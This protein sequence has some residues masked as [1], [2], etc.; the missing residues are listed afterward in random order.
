MFQF[1]V[2]PRLAFANDQVGWSKTYLFNTV[3]VSE[4]KILQQ[5]KISRES[6]TVELVSARANLAQKDAD[7]KSQWIETFGLTDKAKVGVV[8]KAAKSFSGWT[9]FIDEWATANSLSI[10]NRKL[11][12]KIEKAYRS[13]P[14]ACQMKDSEAAVYRDHHLGLLTGANTTSVNSQNLVSVISSWNTNKVECLSMKL[15][16]T[17]SEE[18]SKG[19]DPA[20]LFRALEQT[21]DS[22]IEVSHYTANIKFLHATRLVQ[23]G[24]YA[25]S[26]RKIF[27]LIEDYPE[28]A[29][30]YDS[31]QRIY[32]YSQKG[33]GKVALKGI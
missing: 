15:M 1:L 16:A 27:E 21:G 22:R 4:H 17:L 32:S 14:P 23:K 24:A 29:I 7:K 8:H 2:C 30:I 26:L 12:T 10:D 9:N 11:W 5:N 6:A 20:L 25:E 28:L 31:V 18:L 13:L 19:L 3:F 33:Q